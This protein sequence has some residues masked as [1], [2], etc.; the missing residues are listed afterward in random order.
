MAIRN[1]EDR[2]VRK[3]KK[4]LRMALTTLLLKKDLDHITVRDVA[5][6]ADV[7]RGTFYAHYK[8][9]EE[10]LK[11]LEEELFAE[12]QALGERYSGKL[13]DGDALAYLTELF[14]MA[15]ENSDM[16]YA[17]RATTV[18]M[19]FQHRLYQELTRQYLAVLLEKQELPGAESELIVAFSTSGLISMAVKWIEGG[20]KEAPA[21]MARLCGSL[22]QRGVYAFSGEKE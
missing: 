7:N 3:T 11:Q 9:V 13:E 2:R 17:L 10:L 22:I 15:G 20:K 14:T 4:Q 5:E 8:D 19:D 12:L 16:V 21:E 1:S 6:L 18:D